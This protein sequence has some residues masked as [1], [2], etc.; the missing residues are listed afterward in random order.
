MTPWM[1]YAGRDDL[2][3]SLSVASTSDFDM[4]AE[5]PLKGGSSLVAGEG[6]PAD[7]DLLEQTLTS[8]S[9]VTNGTCVTVLSCVPATSLYL[10]L[11]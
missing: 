11:E 9:V 10:A 3:S 7:F 6:V 8:R 4:T 2:L 5:A 1:Q